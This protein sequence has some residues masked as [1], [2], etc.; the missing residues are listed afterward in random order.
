MALITLAVTW[1]QVEYVLYLLFVDLFIRGALVVW[2]LAR[3]SN[4]PQTALTWV[5]LLIGLPIFGL[6]LYLLIGE[7]RLGYWR[8]KRH[9]R[10]IAAIDRP[11]VRASAD[12]KTVANLRPRDVQI[13]AL[14]ERVSDSSTV[15]GNRLELLGN[16]AEFI[17]RLVADM[18][19]AKKH[20]HIL[21]FIY[22]TDE[23]G[24][25]VADGLLRASARGI[26]CRLLVDAVG[27]KSFLKS[28]L[29]KK[30]RAGG[31]SLAAALPVNPIR[32]LLSRLDLRNHRK[33]AIIDGQIGYTGSN[34]LADAAF[35]IK[36]KYAPWVDCTVRID[37]PATKEL[38]V[39]FLEDWYLETDEFFEDKLS[40]RPET[41]DDGLPIQ[42]IATGPNFYTEATTQIVQACTQVVKAELV[43]TTP[44][45][46]PDQA[47]LTNL[48]V[49]A[50]RGVEVY[51][52]LP[53]RNDSRLV[54]AASRSN[55]KVLLDAGVRVMEYKKGLLHA[56]TITIDKDL[57]V[58]MSA[59][60]DR[61]SYELN[62]ECGAIIYDT[63]FA[64]QLRLLQQQYIDESDALDRVTWNQRPL[65]ARVIDTAAGLMSPLL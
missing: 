28:P 46:V 35:A 33:I 64:S 43:L 20:V 48:C 37:G 1:P 49:A 52:V 15:A 13:S 36:A 7:S 16:S 39:L 2:V 31:V 11:E 14:A 56:K 4:S 17:D 27:S 8:R 26:D 23:S 3:K 10:A 38:E 32:M 59:N 62:F 24:N 9:A 54:A 25:K 63:D 51:L 29:C 12:P 57:A 34:N 65:Q 42:V 22:L 21:T 19:N 58:V 50:R 47:T 44:Y 30:L 41:H 40:F 5:V 45:F 53:K 6:I 60:L 61:R 55:Y 18:D